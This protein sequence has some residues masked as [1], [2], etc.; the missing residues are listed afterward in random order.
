M[1]FCWIPFY[2]Q[3]LI[4]VYKMSIYYDQCKCKVKKEESGLELI[5]KNAD[6]YK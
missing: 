3:Q 2:I 5:K 6:T 1:L 4:G